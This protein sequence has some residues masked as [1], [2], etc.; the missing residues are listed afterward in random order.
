[1]SAELIVSVSGITKSTLPALDDFRRALD[2]R[3]VPLSL[4]VSP[5]SQHGYRLER[6][7]TAIE[8]LHQRR[9]EGA[10]IVLNGFDEAASKKLRGEF[11]SLSAHEANLRLAAADRVLEHVDLR[12]RLFAP[13]GWST[14]DD[15]EIALKRHAFRVLIG[16]SG[17]VDLVRGET[18]RSRVLGIGAGFVSDP[19]WCRALV[20]GVERAARRG[21]S[22]RLAVSARHL[23]RQAPYHAML[24]SIDL[25]MMHG[26]HPAVYRWRSGSALTDAA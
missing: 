1:M 21:G 16:L 9:S 11:A 8:W 17:T 12:T 20:L 15:T 19:W 6:D 22:V 10:A 25:A 4:F 7:G 13:P 3:G 23:A 24:D 5:R 26:C 18:R 2:V 14:S